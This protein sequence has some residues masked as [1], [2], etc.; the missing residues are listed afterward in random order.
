MTDLKIDI[1]DIL[2]F[3]GIGIL[4]V[5]LTAYENPEL[6]LKFKQFGDFALAIFSFILGNIAYHI[7]RVLIYSFLLLKFKDRFFKDQKYYCRT[8]FKALLG[9]PTTT[10]ANNFF[11]F[12][13]SKKT[14]K[15]LPR[16]SASV[17]LMYMT[18]IIL[19]GYSIYKI[20]ELNFLIAITFLVIAVIIFLAA[21]LTDRFVEKHDY[22]EVRTIDVDEI[23]KIWKEYRNNQLDLLP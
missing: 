15:T 14:L 5:V 21:F 19:F 16:E 6:Y 9:C 11:Y 12:L 3:T 4:I 18:S 7:Y 20:F 22:S 2:R 23:K 13:R 17:H 10:E 1:N 8:Y